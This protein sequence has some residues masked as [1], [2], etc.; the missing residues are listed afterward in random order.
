[1]KIKLLQDSRV[2]LVA[3]TEVEV[4]KEQAD[5]LISLG[6]AVEEKPKATKTTAKKK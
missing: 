6:R 5:M 3:G 4:S 1:M 2:A